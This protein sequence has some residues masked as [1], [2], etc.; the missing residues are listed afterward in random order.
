VES[1]KNKTVT[2]ELQI[3]NKKYKVQ[4]TLSII[5]SLSL[6]YSL[7]CIMKYALTPLC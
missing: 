7:I 3:K 2:F 1:P 6:K 4:C 5:Y